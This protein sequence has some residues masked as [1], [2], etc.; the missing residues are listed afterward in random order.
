MYEDFVVVGVDEGFPDAGGAVGGVGGA[1]GH[2]G[3][4]VGPGCAAVAACV[5]L[6]VKRQNEGGRRREGG[7]CEGWARDLPRCWSS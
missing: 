7:A 3:R 2:D 1:G 5:D 6:C 4:D